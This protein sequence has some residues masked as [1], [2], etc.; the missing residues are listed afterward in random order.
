MFDY[1]KTDLFLL[2]AEEISNTKTTDDA[3]EIITKELLTIE[4]KYINE[5]LQGLNY[6]QSDKS[7]QWIEDNISRTENII[8]NW[9]YLAGISKFNWKIAEKWLNSGRP[10]SLVALD[11]INFCTTKGERLNQSLMMREINP[12]MIDNPNLEVIAKKISE[13]HK[14][15][16]S[17][18]VKRVVNS[19]LQNLFD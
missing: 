3:F 16:N 7:L 11:A 4:N 13:Y 6:L 18:R 15:D 17:P 12:K 19:I 8:L 14:E 5:C 2:R 10:L 1:E 9:G